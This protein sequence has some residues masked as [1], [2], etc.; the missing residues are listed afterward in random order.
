MTTTRIPICFC[1][2]CSP[3]IRAVLKDGKIIRTRM[4][5]DVWT[6]ADPHEVLV[7]PLLATDEQV[8]EAATDRGRAHLLWEAIVDSGASVRREA[9]DGW[10]LEDWDEYRDAK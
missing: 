9:I 8:Q 2:D 5:Y 7:S 6:K 10:N 3:G 4:Q 1:K